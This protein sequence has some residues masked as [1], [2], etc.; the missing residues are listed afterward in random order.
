MVGGRAVTPQTRAEIVDTI[1]QALRDTGV[2]WQEPRD[3][4][5][6][7]DLPG[8][9]KLA[10]PCQLVVGEHALAIHDVHGIARPCAAV[11]L[12]DGAGKQPRMT[13]IERALFA[14]LEQKTG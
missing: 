7:F 10:T 3:G 13:A 12:S 5:F 14:G 8:E 9:R 1:R 4:V 6:A 11:E 2:E